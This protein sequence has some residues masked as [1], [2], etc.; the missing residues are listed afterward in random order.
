MHR[1]ADHKKTSD[2]SREMALKSQALLGET[3]SESVQRIEVSPAVNAAGGSALDTGVKDH[4][5][6]IVTAVVN[7]TS[8]PALV[9]SGASRSFISDRFHCKPPLHFV[10]AYSALEL[11]NGETIVST[12]IAPRVLVC[13]GNIPCRLSLTAVPMMEG[14]Q[15]ILGKDW[16]DSVNP[17]VDWRS[18]IMYLRY[19]SQ[20]EP[21]KGVMMKSGQCNQIVD[22]GLPGLQCYFGVLR[23]SSKFPTDDK[24]G[25]RLAEL[26]SPHFWQYNPSAKVWTNQQVHQTCE[27][28][29]RTVDVPKGGVNDEKFFPEENSQPQDTSRCKRMK[30]RKIAGKVVKQRVKKKL[31]FCTVRQAAR[32]ANKTDQPM[33]L[34]VIKANTDP[35]TCWT[36]ADPKLVQRKV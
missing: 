24:L 17:L 30:T 1:T 19:G 26:Y 4:M 29:P 33:F 25:P 32:T 35:K 12:G 14:I 16:L 13:I 22:K 21:I 28:S 8:V 9:D 27:S 11:A 5:L 15:L 23:N 20:L 2:D 34:C 10:G 3:P 6:L 7:G 31:D 36:K 18:N